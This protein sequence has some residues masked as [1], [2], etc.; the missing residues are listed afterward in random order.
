MQRL[1][2][3]VQ[4]ER[5]HVVFNIGPG[6]GRVAAGEGTE[7]AGRHAHGAGAFQG[8]FQPDLGFAPE[9]A[10]QGVER[11]GA[12]HL[13]DGADLQVVLQVG[14]HAGQ[15]VLHGNAVALQQRRRANA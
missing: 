6:L 1:A 7:L 4:A 15:V 5:L 14:A 13:E 11:G 3:G 10:G 2:K 8:V 9:R 12:L